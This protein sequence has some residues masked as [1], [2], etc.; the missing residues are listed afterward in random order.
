MNI[1]QEVLSRLD[2]LKIPYEMLEHPAARTMEDCR[3]VEEHFHCVMPKNLFLT[4]R[5]QSAFYLC[6]TRPDAQ[7]RTADVSKQLGASRLS[8]GS[9]EML[10]ELLRTYPGAISPM[11]LLFDENRRV[12]LAIDRA[13]RDEPLL[14][15]HPCENTAS[16]A[17]TNESFFG[18]LLPLLHREPVWVDV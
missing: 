16:L 10:E 11:G 7:F 17:L 14:A 13:L 1:R 12:C 8:F 3:V 2:A 5:N 6:V 9:P 18:R 4:P 15:F